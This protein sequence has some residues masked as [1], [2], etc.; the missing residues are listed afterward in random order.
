M[1]LLIFERE[2]LWELVSIDFLS[3]ERGGNCV[4]NVKP[5]SGKF[6]YLV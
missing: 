5:A 1:I 2:I 6:L 3:R 4:G